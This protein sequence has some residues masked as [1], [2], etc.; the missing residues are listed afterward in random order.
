MA[1]SRLSVWIMASRPKTLWAGIAP[2][3]IGTVMAYDA[4]GFHPWSAL[5]ALFGAL[6]IQVGTNFANDYSDH[7]RGTDR[8]DRIGPVR[9]TQAGLV[10]PETM[11]KATI[12]VFSLAFLAGIYLA[13]RGGWPVVI[14]GLASIAFGI[15]YTAGPAPI[16]YI[17]LADLFVLIFFG[18]VATGGTYYVQTL[19]INWIVIVAGLSPG[20]FSVAILTVN[21][22][23]DMAT[24]HI[25]G[26]RTLAVRLGRR[27]ARIEYASAIVIASIL[28]LILMVRPDETYWPILTLLVLPVARPT[29]KQVF[30]TTDG[31]TLNEA[32]ATTGRLL[33]VFSL[34][35]SLGWLL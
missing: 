10:P 3:I 26:K 22:L 29:I 13:Y 8:V 15:L 24:D 27:F 21:N 12:V 17:G 30:S 35:F 34:L 28:P 5:A 9:V 16:G 31:E 4:G 32:L 19:S 1:Q 25:S 11:K 23:R 14:I 20:L 6:M 7:A 33:L 18:P 2:V